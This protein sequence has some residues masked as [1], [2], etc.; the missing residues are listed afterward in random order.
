MT[1][2]PMAIRWFIV[3]A[4]LTVWPA[5]AFAQGAGDPGDV[6]PDN[7]PDLLD[8]TLSGK[9]DLEEDERPKTGF[10]R[11]PTALEPW[12]MFKDRIADQ[13]GLHF[14]GSWGVLWQD[15]SNSLIDEEDSVGQKLTFNVSWEILNRGRPNT[16]WYELVV[17]D[18][19]PMGTEFAPLQAGLTTGTIVPTAATWGEFDLGVTQNYIRQDLFNHSVQY[20]VGKVFAP[21]F[22]NPFPFFDDNRQFL[23][24]TFSTS[25][26]IPAPLR[27]FGTVVAWYPTQLGLYVKGGMYTNHSSD[28]G[29][30]ADE[31]FS[32]PEHFYHVEAGWS[33][34]AR[35]GVPVQARGPMDANNFSVTL[36]HRDA[37]DFGDPIFHPGS[38]GIAFN[39][40]YMIFENIMAFARGGSSEGWVTDE[41]VTV[42]FGW[43]PRVEY[44]D[45]FGFGVGWAQ[46][47]NA[48]LREQYTY[49]VF[50]RFMLTPNLALTPDVQ[51]ITDPALDPSEDELWVFSFRSRVTF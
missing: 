27:G 49:E 21:N 48:L 36:W 16:L 13:Y 38:E 42:G 39:A 23:N 5:A 25:P 3:S 14:G 19:G 18:R 41:N 34:L 33:G 17:E 12:F 6:Y 29:F 31:F 46:P 37:Q 50:Y 15:Y 10:F 8:G 45:L 51:L 2:S 44:S 40:N 35:S 9:G 4:V 20:A 30:T 26:T 32:D 22:I 11:L 24:Q 43:R 28:T 1:C 47:A 7:H